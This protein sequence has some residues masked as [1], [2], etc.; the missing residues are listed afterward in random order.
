M[1]W[2][3]LLG[4]LGVL[5]V[6]T[7]ATMMMP[8]S[9]E[10][11]LGTVTAFEVAKTALTF[12]AVARARRCSARRSCRSSVRRFR[13]A[14]VVLAL[15]PLAVPIGR[16]LVAGFDRTASPARSFARRCRSRSR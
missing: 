3:T 11:R 14:L 7:Q 13:S 5:L 12:V 16:G 9:V 1:V 8:L 10:L 2:G 4:G 6:N 15:T